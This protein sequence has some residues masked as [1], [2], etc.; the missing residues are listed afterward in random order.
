MNI[1]HVYKITS[2]NNRIYIGSSI[3]IKKRII[4]YKYCDCHG[5]KKL[6]F[7]LKKHGWVNHIFEIIWTGPVEQMLEKETAIG[8]ELN[9]LS[10]YNL[11]CKLP[12]I[13]DVFCFISESTRQKMR[14]SHKKRFENMSEEKRELLGK[15]RIGQKQSEFSLKQRTQKVQISVKQFALNGIFVKK[16]ESATIAGK[17]L[18]VS[19]SDICQCCKNKKK[20]CGGFIWKYSIEKIQIKNRKKRIDENKRSNKIVIQM[21]LNEN[22]IKEWSCINDAYRF[23]NIKNGSHISSCCTGNRKTAYNFK[24][25]YKK[26][27]D[28]NIS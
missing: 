11:N 14:E 9:V 2:P 17:T 22:F 23:L 10:S 25:K 20:T 27:I 24:W 5:Q 7:S 3:N 12:K 8:L 16:W 4:K 6:Y 26:T 18:K 1:G 21:D 13:K 19:S 28:E 15:K